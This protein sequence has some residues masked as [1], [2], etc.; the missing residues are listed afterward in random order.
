MSGE[1]GGEEFKDGNR[2]QGGRGGT[3]SRKQPKRVDAPGR[4]TGTEEAG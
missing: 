3:H 2:L 1:G 4:C